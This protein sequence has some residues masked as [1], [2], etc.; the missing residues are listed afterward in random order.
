[1]NEPA[2]LLAP[3]TSARRIASLDVLRVVALLGI[4]LMNI[5]AMNSTLVRGSSGIDPQLSGPDLWLDA[6]VYV[7]VQGKFHPLFSI[8]FGMGFALMLDRADAAGGNGVAVYLRRTLVLLLIGLAHALL[9]WPGDIL[10][11]YALMAL[12]LL[13]FRHTPA[14]RLWRWALALCGGW[15]VLLWLLGF[16]AGSAAGTGQWVAEAQAELA[17]W[18]AAQRQ[19]FGFG[20]YAEATAQRWAD[21]RRVLKDLPMHLL[22][23]LGL[24]VFGAWAV[25]S[26]VVRDPSAHLPLLRGGLGAGLGLGGALM[27]L[28]A[29][30]WPQLPALLTAGDASALM[31]VQL[32]QW[33]MCLGYASAIVLSLQGPSL[34][35]WAG[36]LAPAGRMALSNYLLQSLLAAG[37]FHGYGLGMFEQVSRSA[38]VLLVLLV[39][40]AQVLVS[41]WWLAR[42]R[43]GP[44]EWLWR[45]AS[46]ASRPPMRRVAT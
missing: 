9:L 44:V 6:L 10:V 38:Q 3:T 35:R 40:A 21:L 37:V 15:L 17:R 43:F 25:R 33:L 8:L 2:T 22:D 13:L 14:S 23:Q 24:F 34:P 5:E 28:S 12:P 27:L 36:W 31:L 16:A 46:Y 20:S 7:L 45:W 42:F 41:H 11:S 1:M 39:F 18:D 4:F 32:A 29:W 26:G 30:R 19:A